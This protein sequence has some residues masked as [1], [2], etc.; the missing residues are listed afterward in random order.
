[1]YKWKTNPK[2]ANSVILLGINLPESFRKLYLIC[3]EKGNYDK[4]RYGVVHLIN[5]L[6]MGKV[7]TWSF[8]ISQIVLTEIISD[9]TFSLV[10]DID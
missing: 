2:P 6:N 9:M 8:P 1:M 7:Q 3:A 4:W 10:S 5:V